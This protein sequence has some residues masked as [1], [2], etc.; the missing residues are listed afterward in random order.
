MKRNHKIYLATAI[1]IIVIIVVAY[2]FTAFAKKEEQPAAMAKPVAKIQ[3]KEFSLNVSPSDGQRIE[4]LLS[5]MANTNAFG[6]AFKRKQLYTIG[7]ILDQH[8]PPFQFLAYIFSHPKLV[9]DMKRIRKSKMKYDNFVEGLRKNL[10][11]EADSKCFETTAKGFIAFLGVDE[12]K[13]LRLLDLGVNKGRID[14]RS[15]KPLVNFLI[16]EMSK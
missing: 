13:T 15:F 2:V 5:T 12:E 8:V 3:C 16:D 14:K 10:L 6:L 9:D 1:I 11:K 4:T 7:D